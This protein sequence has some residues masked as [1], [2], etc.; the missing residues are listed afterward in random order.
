MNICEHRIPALWL[1]HIS[2]VVVPEGPLL[3]TYKLSI[4]HGSQRPA[5]PGNHPVRD[6]H[7][8][9]MLHPQENSDGALERGHQVLGS[10]QGTRSGK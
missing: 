2:T 6:Y 5:P 7:V 9:L 1:V 8:I 4:F 10:T 3:H